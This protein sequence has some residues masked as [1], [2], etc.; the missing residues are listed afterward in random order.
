M[1]LILS[2][3]Q[4]IITAVL[5]VVIVACNSKNVIPND[6][7]ITFCPDSISYYVADTIFLNIDADAN[8]TPNIS[9]IINYNDSD[10]Y[11]ALDNQTIYSYNIDGNYID[12]VIQLSSI[13]SLKSLSGFRY[14]G[15]YYLIY[16]YKSRYIYKIDTMGNLISK[17]SLQEISDID[18]WGISGTP[19]LEANSIVYMSGPPGGKAINRDINKTSISVN[20]STGEIQE[21]GIR[22]DNYLNYNMGRDYFWRVCHTLDSI[23]NLVV[24]LPSSPN[25]YV[26][27]CNLELVNEFQMASRYNGIFTEAAS[28]MSSAEE[29]LYYLMHDSYG[30]IEY[31]KYKKRFYR[32][33][34][35]PLTDIKL[36][37]RT[38]KPFSIIVTDECGHYIC[39]TPIL[40]LNN[41][42]FY[43]ILG[44]TPK[45]LYIQEHNID[46]NVIKFII[47]K[48][49]Q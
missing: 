37:R 38:L 31:D 45:G 2:K 24:S 14:T 46:E 15:E 21:G 17:V 25:V 1:Q 28:G 30:A 5:A 3:S 7:G 8:P 22:P 11:I 43:D 34:T 20:L 16:D 10:Y 19:I 49:R 47:L 18:P 39:E 44:V 13:P 26:F 29:K 41:T 36:G 40:N 42:I 9:Q 23:G 48:E 4:A 35:H 12:N 27:D 33:A 6:N 32:I